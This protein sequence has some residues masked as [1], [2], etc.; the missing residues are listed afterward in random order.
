[1]VFVFIIKTFFEFYDILGI[2]KF[3]ILP[4][5]LIFQQFSWQHLQFLSTFSSVLISMENLFNSVKLKH[6]KLLA[7]IPIALAPVRPAH[8]GLRRGP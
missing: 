6:L 4:R 2:C 7:I 3:Q 5:Y 1:M 8:K